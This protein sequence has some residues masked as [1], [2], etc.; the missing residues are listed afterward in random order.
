[1]SRDLGEHLR[2]QL[3]SAL[4]TANIATVAGNENLDKQIE[5]LDRLSTNIYADKYP[6]VHSSTASGLSGS[7]CS[8]ILSSE[9]LQYLKQQNSK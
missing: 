3:K 1:M 7:Q 8:Q 9:F 2:E 6:R 5:A 4:G